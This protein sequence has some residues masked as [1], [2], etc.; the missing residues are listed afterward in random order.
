MD[1]ASPTPETSIAPTKSSNSKLII[2]GLMGVVLLCIICS[3]VGIIIYLLSDDSDVEVG[4]LP[5]D[6]QE[7]QNEVTI[8][9]TTPIVEDE[10]TTFEGEAV[11][12]ELPTDWEIIEYFDGD[13]TDMVV[14][15]V[16]YNG[17]TS[18]EIINPSGQVV[19]EMDAV[20]G[21][22]GTGYCNEIYSFTDTDPSYISDIET[23]NVAVSAEP[24]SIVPLSET[25]SSLNFL[26]VDV[27]RIVKNLYWDVQSGDSYFDPGCGISHAFH[28]IPDVNFTDGGMSYENHTYQVNIRNNPPAVELN[29]LDDIV[30]SLVSIM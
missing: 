25:Y 15:G 28:E 17:L 26:G 8:T 12:A 13:G 3:L 27:R 9:P 29:I 24:Y 7:Q 6:D 4:D 18:L 30:N 5:T 23:N 20:S 10:Y 22:G 21:I 11:T 2:L 16:T 1:N 14:G 19:L